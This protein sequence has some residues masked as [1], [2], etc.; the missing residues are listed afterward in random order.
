MLWLAAQQQAASA[1]LRTVHQEAQRGQS[2]GP[3]D[4]SSEEVMWVGLDIGRGS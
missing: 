3:L 4:N 1:I 2:T